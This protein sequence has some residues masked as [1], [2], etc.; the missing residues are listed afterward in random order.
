MKV[1]RNKGTFVYKVMKGMEIVS[2]E[3]KSSEMVFCTGAHTE[4][5]PLMVVL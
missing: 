5:T 1:P 2:F 4:L 3:Q